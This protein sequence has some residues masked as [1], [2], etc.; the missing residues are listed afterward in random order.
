LALGLHII[1]PER[2]NVSLTVVGGHMAEDDDKVTLLQCR[3]CGVDL[4][5]ACTCDEHNR[6]ERSN[7]SQVFE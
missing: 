3:D 2:V 6:K 5:R 1:E 4:R 7:S